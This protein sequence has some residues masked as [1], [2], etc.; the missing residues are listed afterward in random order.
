MT[1]PP[2]F[3]LPHLTSGACSTSGIGGDTAAKSGE[4]RYVA[5]MWGA[6]AAGSAS[7][8]WCADA[9]ERAIAPGPQSPGGAPAKPRHVLVDVKRR[10][11]CGPAVD[12]QLADRGRQGDCGSSI[13][14]WPLDVRERAPVIDFMKVDGEELRNPRRRHAH[15]RRTGIAVECRPGEVANLGTLKIQVADARPQRHDPGAE[16]RDGRAVQ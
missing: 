8:L 12:R 11:H 10:G 3:L 16:H 14:A 9:A 15:A 1:G 13:E 6:N 2:G 4:A 7:Q 5:T